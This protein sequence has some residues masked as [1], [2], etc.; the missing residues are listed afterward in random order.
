MIVQ[1]LLQYHTPKLNSNIAQCIPTFGQW[2]ERTWSRKLQDKHSMR[3]RP[4]VELMNRNNNDN[5]QVCL[6]WANG[7]VEC[8]QHNT[9]V[10]GSSLRKWN[11]IVADLFQRWIEVRAYH[12]ES[13][14]L[15]KPGL[16]FI[17]PHIAPLQWDMQLHMKWHEHC[18][19]LNQAARDCHKY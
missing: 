8:K 16:E 4:L 14:D 17:L 5:M 6:N 13:L 1:F 15:G 11:Q 7:T 3:N 18:E 10:D 9:Y 2:T 19:R 12:I